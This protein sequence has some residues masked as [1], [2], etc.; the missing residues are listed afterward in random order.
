MG[1]WLIEVEHL[2]DASYVI[3]LKRK[4]FVLGGNLPYRDNKVQQWLLQS[5]TMVITKC[6]SGY[7]KVRQ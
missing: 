4:L 7:Y 5:A 2:F 3:K 6:D 1:R